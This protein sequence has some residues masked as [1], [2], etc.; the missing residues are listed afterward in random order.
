MNLNKIFFFVSFCLFSFSVFGQ[1]D[2]YWDKERATKKEI[3]V[4]ARDRIVVKTDDFPVGTTELIYRITLLDEN[5]Q[6]ASSLVSVLKSIPDPTGISQ[7]SAGA[8]FL[9]S[10]IS[11]NDK[12]KYAIFTNE[13]ATKDYQKKGLVNQSCFVQ[14][15]AISKDA[16]RISNTKSSC[17][18]SNT[19]ALWFGF[20][21]KN[22]VMKQ[23]IILEVV[24]WVNT[25]LSRGWNLENR[26]N[27]LSQIKTSEIAKKISNADSFCLCVSEKVQK[28]FTFQEF[29]QL[30]SIEKTKKIND[31]GTICFGETGAAKKVNSY[32]RNQVSELIK[33]KNYGEAISKLQTIINDKNANVSDYQ[34]IGFAFILTKQFD[35]A[36]KQLKEGEKLDDTDLLIKLNL[37]HAYLLKKDF[38]AAKSI[39]KK[40]QSQ[41]VTDSLAW[42]QK[43]KL[44]FE[45]FKKAGLVSKDFEKVLRI[46]N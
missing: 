15:E 3:T 39:H 9:L 10:K 46:L 5:Q 38:R 26:K 45:V 25:N 14:K 40:Y 32:L 7:G 41:N 23:K 24:P 43:V 1:Q 11:G 20:E 13:F 36:I 4:S 42:S 44:D 22:W 17:F 31:L 2:G 37:A 29:Q 18:N 12:C 28:E 34:T 16:K 6:L 27:I 21:S 8:V 33:Q 30:L 19:S 35:K